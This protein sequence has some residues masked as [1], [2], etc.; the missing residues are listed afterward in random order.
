MMPSSSSKGVPGLPAQ[1]YIAVQ[2]RCGQKTAPTKHGDAMPCRTRIE[3]LR[4]G[5]WGK[6]GLESREGFLPGKVQAF[7]KAFCSTVGFM[8]MRPG[9]M[10]SLSSLQIPGQALA[11]LYKQQSSHAM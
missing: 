3:T 9:R 7:T 8:V 11:N 4:T 1:F 5:L 2:N 6:G 10:R